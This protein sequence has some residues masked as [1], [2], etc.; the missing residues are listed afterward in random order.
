MKVILY[1]AGAHGKFLKFL[2]DCHEQGKIFQ[3][4]F[5]DNGNS[6]DHAVSDESDVDRT[7]AFD[8][9][10]PDSVQ[11]YQQMKQGAS[12]THAIVWQ[13]L[14]DF[15]YV[16]QAY[17][18]RGGKLRQPGIALLEKD[19]LQYEQIYGPEVSISKVLKS[20][21]G[22][23]CHA[24]GQPPRSV[25]RNYFMLTLFTYFQH[26]CWNKNNELQ[27]RSI[28]QNFD[29]ISLRH[30]LDYQ[31]L[32]VYMRKIFS[33]SMDF[34]SV[35]NQFLAA[36]QVLKQCVAVNDIL[37]A[38]DEQKHIKITGLNVI[39]ESYILFALETK[40]FD[41]PFL[42]GNSFF[43]NTSD[44]MSYIKY[45]PNNMKKPNNLFCKYYQH[46]Q[47]RDPGMKT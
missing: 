39:S 7:H 44:L 21:F 45:F 29:T 12:S 42:L 28:E 17:T 1:T 8:I 14:E 11:M 6:H 34:R 15:H 46:F 37:R 25:L 38:L 10:N 41:I 35:H 27:K 18:D 19:V 22:F 33:N 5:N 20:C 31:L 30:I 13:G 4:S 3:P 2:F 24:L 36:N 40:Y 23:D 47:R 9:C 26:V 32:Q 43:D 16:L